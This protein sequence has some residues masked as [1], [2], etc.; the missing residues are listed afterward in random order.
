MKFRT[1]LILLCAVAALG[2]FI[3]YIERRTETTREREEQARRA[4]QINAD[5]ATYARFETS[6]LVA[7]CVREGEHW[8][9]VQPVNAWADDSE[10]DRILTGFQDLPR[11]EVITAE[12]QKQRHLSPSQYGLRTPRARITIGDTLY[13]RTI[14]VGQDAPVGGSLY[15]QE[16]QRPDIVAT[17]SN[18]LALIPQD[19]TALR[20]RTVFHGEPEHVQQLEIQST[21]G[22]LRI[23]RM[24]G[25]KW[26]LQQPARGRASPAV[27]QGM[28][29]ALA[30][31]RVEEFV[32]EKGAD[33]VAYGL[34]EPILKISV[35]FGGEQEKATLLLGKN[36]A[37]HPELIYAKFLEGDSVFD[38][39][40][41][42]VSQFQVDVK[43]ARDRRLVLL[44]AGDIGRIRISQGE[45]VLELQKNDEGWRI[46]E[47]RPWKA[48]EA[49]VENT[50]NTWAGAEILSFVDDGKTNLDEISK[51]E[52]PFN[53][54]FARTAE[55]PAG[56]EAEAGSARAGEDEIRMQVSR[57]ARTRGRLLVKLEN[58]QP[59]YVIADKNPDVFSM[60]PLFYR[61]R[62]ILNLDAKDIVRITVR[63]KG[64]EKSVAIESATNI[65]P[66]GASGAAI[67]PDVVADIIA[68][69]STLRVDRYVAENP[70]DPATFGLAEPAAVLTIGLA[71]ESGI[72]KTILFGGDAGR[73]QVYAMLRG[74]NIVFVLDRKTCER[75]IAEPFVEASNSPGDKA[76][77]VHLEKI[78]EP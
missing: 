1:T 44:P 23:A 16:E 22:F 3:R 49:V 69:A 73:D 42:F 12:D 48:E 25:G 34:D 52:A 39:L 41:N 15:I 78:K 61:D 60:D 2:L 36:A 8:K 59:L 13:R 11:G 56:R 4:L 54:Y 67:N 66:I 28:L 43:D 46:I 35:S 21:E 57:T 20:D 63:T 27:V 6:N 65:V 9:I 50:I 29:D 47:P 71:G 14:R 17:S 68:A 37:K 30:G 45:K 32:A 72:G 51:D 64:G 33:L 76:V 40:T 5:K 55:A 74:E 10:M 24:E 75:L 26:M 58:E 19:V 77:D 31:L 38:V 70:D 53:V 18:L 62:N 7:E